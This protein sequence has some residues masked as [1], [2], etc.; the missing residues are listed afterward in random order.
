MLSNGIRAVNVGEFS[1]ALT[2][3]KGQ[4]IIVVVPFIFTF[5]AIKDIKLV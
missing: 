5:R 1:Q 4:P 2:N 3:T